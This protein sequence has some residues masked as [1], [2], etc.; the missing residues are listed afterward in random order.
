MTSMEEM[1][2]KIKTIC[3]DQCRVLQMRKVT[4]I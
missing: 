2:K 1:R 4:S 3:I